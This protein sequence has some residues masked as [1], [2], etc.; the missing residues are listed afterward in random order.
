[1]SNTRRRQAGGPSRSQRRSSFCHRGKIKAPA[2]SAVAART[3][4][5]IRRLGLIAA[6]RFSDELFFGRPQRLSRDGNITFCRHAPPAP[7]SPTPSTPW[8]IGG[9]P[10]GREPKTPAQAALGERSPALNQRIDFMHGAA[11][12]A[13]GGSM[14]TA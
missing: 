11:S 14:T 12:S 1:M 13:W 7:E 9:D 6:A 10:R 8:R 4:C 2:A 5:N 3:S